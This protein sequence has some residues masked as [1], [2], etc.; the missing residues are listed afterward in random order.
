M[1]KEQAPPIDPSVSRVCIYQ[2]FEREPG[3]CPRCSGALRQQHQLYA[4][5]TRRGRQMTDTFMIS[6]DFGWYCEDC[7]IV[8]INPAKVGEMLSFSK[9]GWDTGEAFAVLGLV[10]LSAVPEEKSHLPLGDDNNPLPLVEFTGAS[11]RPGARPAGSRRSK[12]SS[13]KRSRSERRKRK[14]RR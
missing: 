11:G 3:P 14:R 1:T 8:V 4:I 5:A 7:L 2:E 10:D 13:S 12:H 6:G 9:P